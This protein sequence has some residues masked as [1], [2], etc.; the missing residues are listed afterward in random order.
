[1]SFSSLKCSNGCLLHSNIQIPYFD[2]QDPSCSY[3]RQLPHPHFLRLSPFL[4]LIKTQ[5]FFLFLKETISFLCQSLCNYLCFCVEWS[6]TQ[7]F[8]GWLLHITQSSVPFSFTML[9]CFLLVWFL[10]REVGIFN[11]KL[12]PC[13]YK[14]AERLSSLHIFVY[15]IILKLLMNCQSVYST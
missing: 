2:L 3:S 5:V 12:L 9:C 11:S 13:S 8:S 15:F 6:S 14:N 4:T 1:M 7:I 10:E